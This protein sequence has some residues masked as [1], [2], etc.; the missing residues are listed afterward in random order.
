[1]KKLYVLILVAILS[2]SLIGCQTEEIPQVDIPSKGEGVEEVNNEEEAIKVVEEFGSKLQLVSL[3]SPKDILTKSMEEEYSQYVATGLIYEWIEDPLNA[4]GR[5]TS[6]PWPDRIEILNIEKITDYSFSVEGQ[7][8]EMTNVKGEE[9]RRNV[10]IIVEMVTDKWIISKFTMEQ[11]YENSL[12]Y[13]NRE[14]GFVFDLPFTW[15]GYSIVE[16]NWESNDKTQSGSIINIRHPE[17]TKENLRQD[18]PIMIFNHDQWELIEKEEL[19]VGAAPIGPRKIG[20]NDEYVFALPARYNYGFL[21]GYEE[22]DK[23]FEG[24]PLITNGGK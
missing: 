21:T 6:S 17:W 14:F 1:M 13:E 3:M 23:I 20:E 9:F 15:E 4:P 5:L 16:E 24:N 7:I 10:N 12:K 22:V 2:I 11:N 8:V 19:G 18:I